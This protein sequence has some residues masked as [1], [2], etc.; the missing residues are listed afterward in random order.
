MG[1]SKGFLRGAI[2]P[3]SGPELSSFLHPCPDRL[4]ANCGGK[5][6]VVVSPKRL[7]R[8]AITAYS[9]RLLFGG[10]DLTMRTWRAAAF[11]ASL[12]AGG[13]SLAHHSRNGRPLGFVRSVTLL[14]Q[15]T[16]EL[17]AE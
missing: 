16:I 3:I 2:V 8:Q 15:R 12:L 1:C 5:S 14:S 9:R 11:P 7:R 10:N 6:R 13:S 4:Q 17:E